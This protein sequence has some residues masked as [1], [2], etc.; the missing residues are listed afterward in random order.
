MRF[1]QEL[2]GPVLCLFCIFED[3]VISACEKKKGPSS[4]H[5]WIAFFKSMTVIRLF[6]AILKSNFISGTQRSQSFPFRKGFF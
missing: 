4:S 5:W 6:P 3:I 1:V 2:T